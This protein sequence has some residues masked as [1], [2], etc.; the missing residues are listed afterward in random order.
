MGVLGAKL[1]D[2]KACMGSVQGSGIELVTPLTVSVR[3]AGGRSLTFTRPVTRTVTPVQG[4]AALAC[5][6]TLTRKRQELYGS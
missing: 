4:K 3:E 6:T 2:L 5:D 1:W